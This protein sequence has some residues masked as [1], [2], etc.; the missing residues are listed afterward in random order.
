[1]AERIDFETLGKNIRKLRERKQISQSELAE[2]VGSQQS[3]IGYVERADK[4][5]SLEI[6]YKIAKVLGT[7][8][9]AL[10]GQ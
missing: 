8:V 10:L 4:R 5:P 9:D 6:T 1:M 2:K 7:T 3:Y